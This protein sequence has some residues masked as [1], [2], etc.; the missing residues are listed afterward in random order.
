[1][2]LIHH[3]EVSHSEAVRISPDATGVILSGAFPREDLFNP[4]RHCETSFLRSQSLELILFLSLTKGEGRDSIGFQKTQIP[5]TP[6]TKGGSFFLGFLATK[7]HQFLIFLFDSGF[8]IL[9]MR[10]PRR[11]TKKRL[12]SSQ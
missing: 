8:M 1:M 3:S 4:I 7:V 12:T 9:R 2:P 5:L 11:S 6:F 10:L